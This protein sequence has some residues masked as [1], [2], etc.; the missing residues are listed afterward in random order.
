MK[1]VLAVKHPLHAGLRVVVG[2]QVLGG[3]RRREG[4]RDNKVGGDEAEQQE[5]KELAAPAGEMLFQQAGDAGSMRR[6][7]NNIEIN[8]QGGEE[9][10]QPDHD[11]RQRFSPG[12]AALGRE[13]GQITQRAEAIQTHQPQN[14]PPGIR[15]Q[16]RGQSGTRRRR[17]RACLFGHLR[18]PPLRELP[19]AHRLLHRNPFVSFV[20]NPLTRLRAQG[21]CEYLTPQTCNRLIPL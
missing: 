1:H 8:R 21:V 16:S 10:E 4:A 3:I 11:G 20:R 7:A 12:H 5:D 6:P 14:Q 13:G 19:L 2:Q 9:D 17:F 18:R 15:G